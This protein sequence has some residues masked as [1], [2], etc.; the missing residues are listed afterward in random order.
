MITVLLAFLKGIGDL[1]SKKVTHKLN[2]N[3]IK[4]DKKLN[5]LLEILYNSEKEFG[6]K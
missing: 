2:F 6:S 4:G 1:K 5:S 3:K